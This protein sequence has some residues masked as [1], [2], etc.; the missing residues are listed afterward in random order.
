MTN[1]FLAG[2]LP[3]G[4]NTTLMVQL[5]PA[6]SADPQL[7]VCTKGPLS[8]IG[9]MLA[10]PTPVFESTTLCAELCVPAACAGNTR[11]VTDVDKNT[12]GTGVPVP[13]NP[14]DRLTPFV[15][16]IVRVPVRDP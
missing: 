16:L 12:V 4:L 6:G 15:P 7:L 3:E 13:F 2:P 11:F 9:D 5:D 10:V 14:T 1:T 8:V